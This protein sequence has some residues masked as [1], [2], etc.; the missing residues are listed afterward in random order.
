MLIVSQLAL[1]A[2]MLASPAAAVVPRAS[3][4]VRTPLLSG[5]A[6][7][8][9]TDVV[10]Y[11]AAG[12]VPFRVAYDANSE[13]E[14]D[15]EYEVENLLFVGMV[16]TMR[17]EGVRGLLSAPVL[18]GLASGLLKI[19]LT[20]AFVFRFYMEHYNN[21]GHWGQLLS[22][23]PAWHDAAGLVSSLIV[24]PAFLLHRLSGTSE[25]KDG[26]VM[27]ATLQRLQAKH[28]RKLLYAVWSVVHV[29]RVYLKLPCF[30]LA[31]AGLIAYE[32]TG[33]ASGGNFLSLLGD[34]FAAGLVL[35]IDTYFYGLY[36]QLGG[37]IGHANACVRLGAQTQALCERVVNS[38]VL[39]LGI[40]QLAL[41]VLMKTGL[42]KGPN[43]L[44]SLP[45][46][47]AALRHAYGV[48]PTHSRST[49]D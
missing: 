35:E 44:W 2:I 8:P 30:I 1:H 31:N 34:T 37:Q 27:W 48:F 29:V 23:C 46:I 19:T 28:K 38:E 13:L 25:F 40:A 5:A 4:R 14:Q 20:I 16:R 36:K 43:L 45:L 33:V 17:D 12:D 10:A 32:M 39:T 21:M 7:G 22:K 15:K 3:A 49:P 9:P 24:V 18:L 6:S 42:N 41:I 47:A 26:A 11:K